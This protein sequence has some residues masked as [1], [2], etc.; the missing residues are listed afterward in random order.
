MSHVSRLGPA[1]FGRLMITWMLCVA[2]L[3][4]C[5]SNED[6]SVRDTTVVTWPV[7]D[8]RVAGQVI[9]TITNEL[10]HAVDP[11][12]FGRGRQTVAHLLNAEGGD[13]PGAA[14]RVQLNAVPEVLG[15]G[16]VGYLFADFELADPP[17]GVAAARIELNA[18][19][20]DEPISVSVAGFELVEG[21]AGLGAAGRLEWD[22]SGSAV[23]RAIAFDADGRALGYLTTS[24]VR[25]DA[26]DFTMCCFPPTV[27]VDR[28]DDV[29][30]FGVQAISG[31]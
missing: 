2:G 21:E 31:D 15:P 20:S 27:E 10:D 30:V 13:L 28:V 26:G 1:L 22:G 9:V 6:P 23:A 17:G 16:E 4:A 14:A 12:V 3:T 7:A 8:G 25:Y 5:Q 18:A 11:D 24:E 29:V 19:S